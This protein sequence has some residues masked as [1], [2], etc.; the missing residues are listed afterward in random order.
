M[1][2]DDPEEL[3]EEELEEGQT[4][5]QFAESNIQFDAQSIAQII[6][7]E[8]IEDEELEEEVDPEDEPGTI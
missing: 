8:E 4:H 1:H 3:E 6:P 7:E 2:K 5:L